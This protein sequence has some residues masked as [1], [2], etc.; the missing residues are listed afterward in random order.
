MSILQKLTLAE[1]RRHKSRFVVTVLGVLLSTALVAAV[2]LGIDSVMASMRRTVVAQVGDYDW[3]AS[4]AAD[5]GTQTTVPDELQASGLFLELGYACDLTGPVSTDYGRVDVIGVGGD[6]WELLGAVVSEGTLPAA[7]SEA[8]VYADFARKQNLAPGDTLTLPGA[9]G[10]SRSYTVTAVLERFHMDNHFVFPQDDPGD[11]IFTAVTA[12][13]GTG[14]TYYWGKAV[15]ADT[16]TLQAILDLDEQLSVAGTGFNGWLNASLLAWSGVQTPAGGGDNLLTLVG[17]LRMFLLLLIAAAAVLMIYNA[18]S[19]SLAER[20]RTLGM[21]ASAGATP[22]QRSACILYEALAAGVM[23]IPLG[24]AAACAG[25]ALTFAFTAPLIRQVSGKLIDDFSLTLSVRPVWL[26]LSAAAAAG[27]LLISAWVPALHAGRT[28]PIDAIRGAGEVKLSRRALRGGRLFGRVFGP[29]YV[30][31]RKNARRSIHRYRAT[32]LS[33][34][35]SVVLMVTASGFA[36]YLETAYAMG[37]RDSDFNITARLDSYDLTADITA[38]PGFATLNDPENAQA[39]RVR[40]TVQWGATNLPADRFSEEQQELSAQASAANAAMGLLPAV[41]E[42]GSL[43]MSPYLIVLSDEEY[44]ALAGADAASDGQTLD[45]ILVNRYLYTG[46]E[47]GYTDVREQTSF[48]PGDTIDWDFNTLPV[49]LNI[50]SVLDGDDV[51]EELVRTI[52]SA[53]TITFVTGRSA[54]DAVFARF[55]AETGGYCRRNFT[56]SYQAQDRDALMDELGA[57]SFGTNYYAVTDLTAELASLSSAMTLVRVA[58]YGFTALIALVCAANIA[59][60]VSSGMALRRRESAVLRSVGMTPQSLRRMIFWES[61]IYGLKALCWGLPVSGVLL[62]FVWRKLTNLYVFPFSLPWGVAVL[63][64]AAML[65]LCLLSAWPALAR[66]GRTAPAA[67][68]QR[69]D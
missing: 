52:P 6:A 63:A 17:A 31:A 42:D 64:G 9:D 46:S 5:S 61:G 15:S 14:S 18:F 21:L 2:L 53:T 22:E 25:L 48:Q 57:L 69:E 54:A 37:H 20:R 44:A 40:E 58:L 27:V 55:T 36:Q 39:V 67:D 29:E 34:T 10:E 41:N 45:C 66:A 38:A 28:G 24:L 35:M 33:L 50:Q 65:I 51:P 60:T 49:T 56:F 32:L 12:P 23:G 30:L 3:M 11:L 62:W 7:D 43:A 68:L 19:I 1:I 59:N 4:C 47:G 8:A 26:L 16:G 13:A